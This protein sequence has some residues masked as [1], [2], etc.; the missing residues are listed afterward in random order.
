[1]RLYHAIKK[2]GGAAMHNDFI[3]VKALEGELKLS[4]KK[5]R[6]GCTVTTKE[7][8]FQ[9]PHHSYQII[10]NDIISISLMKLKVEV[11]LFRQSILEMKKE[12]LHL[13]ALATIK[14]LFIKLK[15]IIEVVLRQEDVRNLLSLS[16]KKY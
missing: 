9:K 7:M 13:L 15:F 6:F 1:M 10:L 3:Q 12:S 14:Y 16:V 11:S 5:T 2:K 8:V 4:Q